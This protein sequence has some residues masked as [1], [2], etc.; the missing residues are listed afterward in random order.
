MKSFVVI[1]CGRFGLS[2]ANTL[3]ELDNEVMVIDKSEE[4][5]NDISNNVTYAVQADIM[6]ENVLDDLGLS[7]FDVAIIA[8]GSKLEPSIMATLAAKELG[9]KKVIAKAQSERHSRILK[10][11]GA[12][13]VVFPEQD[14]GI[15]IAHN[16]NSTNILDFIEFSPEYGIIEFAPPKKWI[17][18]DLQELSLPSIYSINLLAIKRKSEILI[19]PTKDDIIKVGDILVSIGK[20]ESLETLEKRLGV[21]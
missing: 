13:K 20:V 8:I 3:Y 9:V 17:G 15:K 6:D 12:D 18:K 1:G 4:L 14:M 2:V 19:N 21:D 5:I 7:N 10:K 11:I 16:L